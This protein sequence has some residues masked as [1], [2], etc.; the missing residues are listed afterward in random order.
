MICTQ[1]HLINKNTCTYSKEC[2]IQHW[3]EHKA[4][5]RSIKKQYDE[6][7]SCR[8]DKDLTNGS[9]LDTKEGPC[10]ICLEETTT[11]P[12]ILPCGHIFCYSCVGNYQ[13]ASKILHVD[14]CPNSGQYQITPKSEKA[15]CPYCRGDIP[16]ML[17][18]ASERMF[19]YGSSICVNRG[20]RG[21]KEICKACTC[22]VRINNGSG[23]G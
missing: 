19:L 20:V 10:A 5:C 16:D 8:K 7:K 1:Y 12:V 9:A 15:S 4:E 3:K 2:Q 18:R 22:R 17:D 23:K 21:A 14:I 6:W 13:R 11:N